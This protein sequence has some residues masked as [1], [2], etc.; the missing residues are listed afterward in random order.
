M[1]LQVDPLTGNRYMYAGANP[2]GLLDDG[3]RGIHCSWIGLAICGASR[4]SGVDSPPR[5][6]LSDEAKRIIGTAA[7]TAAL[8]SM[9]SPSNPEDEQDRREV[10]LDVNALRN[11]VLTKLQLN[12]DEEPVITPTV[13]ASYVYQVGRPVP[14]GMRVI[15]DSTDAVLIGSVRSQLRQFNADPTTAHNDSIIGATAL[16]RGIPLITG[17]EDL[18]HSVL[19][20]GGE[21]RM[22][23]PHIRSKYGLAFGAEIA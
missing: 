1:A 2:A 4:D 3:H 14:S 5:P 8:M 9:G 15:P 12:E 7:A 13:A 20:L 22:Y 21:A 19:K 6:I 23:H 16:E 18:W 17:D 10:L 11:P